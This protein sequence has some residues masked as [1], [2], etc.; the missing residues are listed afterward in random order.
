MSPVTRTHV[1]KGKLTASMPTAVATKVPGTR[2]SGRLATPIT[3][4]P[5]QWTVHSPSAPDAVT[6]TSH[7]K[8]HRT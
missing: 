4:Y 2:I 3:Y 7:N 5:A 1:G 8:E 6:G